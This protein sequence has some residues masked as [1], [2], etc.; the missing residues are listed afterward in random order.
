[1]ISA[2]VGLMHLCA[3]AYPSLHAP[4]RMQLPMRADESGYRGPV[5][6]QVLRTGKEVVANAAAG[7]QPPQQLSL[8]AL[9]P[10]PEGHFMTAQAPAFLAKGPIASFPTNP[11]AVCG[12]CAM[13]R[14]AACW[15]E[16]CRTA[17]SL[18]CGACCV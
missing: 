13:L 8:P 14:C 12:G 9:V 18:R 1:M 16:L 4:A 3:L 2:S 10:Q 5:R 7:T 15:A 11:G 17:C 6:T